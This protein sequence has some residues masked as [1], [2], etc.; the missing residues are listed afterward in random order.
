MN[1]IHMPSMHTNYMASG[2]MEVLIY[3]L[4]GML[5]LDCSILNSF[6][7]PHLLLWYEFSSFTADRLAQLVEHRTTVREVVGSN[8]GQTNTQGL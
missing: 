1:H 5:F 4:C 3:F 6:Q 7:S 2:M 8:P